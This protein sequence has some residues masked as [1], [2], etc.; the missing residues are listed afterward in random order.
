MLLKIHSK[1]FLPK[2]QFYTSYKFNMTDFSVQNTLN[3]IFDFK[4]HSIFYKNKHNWIYINNLST[5]KYLY[6][7]SG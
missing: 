3:Y 7:I 1:F 5:R 2:K 4:Y 6:Y